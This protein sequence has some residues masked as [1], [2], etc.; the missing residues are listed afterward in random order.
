MNSVAAMANKG[1]IVFFLPSYA[2]KKATPP[3]ALI[4]LAGPLVK[5]GYDV[6][7]IDTAIEQDPVGAVLEQ[8]EG[9]LCLGISLITGPMIRGAG[10]AGRAVK[11]RFPH[12]PIVLG[13]WHPSILPEQTLEADFVDYV[14][15]KQGEMTMLDLAQR[16][17]CSATVEDVPGILRAEKGQAIWNPARQYPP[18]SHVPSR[19][20]GY[21][22]IDYDAY[23][24]L[25]GLRWLMYSTSHGCP[26]NC[27]YCSNA[28]VYGRNLDVLPVEQVVEEV[29]WLAGRYGI[30]LMGLIDDIF[31][32]PEPL[33]GDRRGFCP[34]GTQLRV[35]HPGPGRLLGQDDGGAG[36]AVPP[37][38]TRPGSFRRGIGV[39]R[40][41]GVD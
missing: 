11:Q 40:R 26:Y 2:S 10:E 28:S 20:P 13:G 37:R 33:S 25:T 19:L 27:G 8:A 41:A 22:L 15:V 5:A 24:R 30:E 1:K 4:S 32:L 7:I 16:F 12:L 18:V 29:T 39:R 14:V 35:V 3:L 17:A 21:D 6:R 23:Q 36:Q 34:Y 31:C 9:A 38:G